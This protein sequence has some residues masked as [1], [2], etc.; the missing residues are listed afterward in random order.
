M[1]KRLVLDNFKIHKHLDINLKNLVLLTGINSSGKS[2]VIQSLLLLRQ[3]ALLGSLNEGLSLSDVLCNVGVAK[4][5]FCQY[6][7]SD[8]MAIQIETEVQSGYW[9]YPITMG[10]GLEKNF[11]KVS[12]CNNSLTKNTSLF[13]KNFQYISIARL[14]PKESYPLD[15]KNVEINNQLSIEKGRCELVAHYLYYWGKEVKK[16]V[17][18]ELCC[19]GVAQDLLSQVSA[20][21]CRIS[22]NVRVEPIKEGS[23]FALKYAYH[24][25]G[26]VDSAEYSAFNV[27]SG[28]SYVLPIIV[29]LLTTEKGGLVI[30]ENPEIHLHSRGQAELTKLIAMA[31]QYGVQVV[32]ETH[33]DHILNGILVASK[34]FEQKRNGIDKENVSIFHFAKD[35]A[36]QLSTCQMVTI[37]GNGEI[38]VQPNDFFDQTEK[39]SNYLMGLSYE[40]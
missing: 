19:E 27:G 3:T 17:P 40:D 28:L 14:E 16:I 33:S 26:D 30:V 32:V 24:K 13:S 23:A 37:V 4:D 25:D 39:D 2:S 22:E 5:V 31:A 35:T 21:E 10:G 1:I 38:D 7:D 36:T 12:S 20:W 18:T 6:A 9:R 15:T 8:E 29:A 34:R 11:L